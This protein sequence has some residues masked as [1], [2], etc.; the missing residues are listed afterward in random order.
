MTAAQIISI[1]L[2][3]LAVIVS[4][5]G[6]YFYIRS[7]IAKAATG[8]VSDA[9]QDGKTGEEKLQTAV[10]AVCA[11]IPVILKPIISRE[12]VKNLVQAAFDKIEEYAKKQAAKKQN[13][14]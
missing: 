14:T 7:K 2:G 8:A 4:F 6:Y 9:E 12:F 10:D 13:K 5:V 3:V 1:V 11:L